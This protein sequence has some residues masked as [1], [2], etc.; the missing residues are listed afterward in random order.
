MATTDAPVT[1]ERDGLP[2]PATIHRIYSQLRAVAHQEL[3][4]PVMIRFEMFDDGD[5]TAVAKRSYGPQA[6]ARIEYDRDRGH[7]I[8]RYAEWA[9][10]DA[11]GEILLER[12]VADA[13]TTATT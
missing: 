9:G 12:V 7:F 1:D 2:A 3:G 5:F 6:E 4:H 11:D 10:D 13:T 8:A